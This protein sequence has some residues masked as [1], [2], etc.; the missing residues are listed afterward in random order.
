MGLPCGTNVLAGAS[1]RT[2]NASRGLPRKARHK[3]LIMGLPDAGKATLARA[4][5]PRLP[6]ASFVV[7]IAIRDPCCG[8][9]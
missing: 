1:W 8:Q 5:T 7:R 4:L 3:I 9:D 2:G 6:L